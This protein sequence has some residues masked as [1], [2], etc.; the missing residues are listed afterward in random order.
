MIRI[1]AAMFDMYG[2]LAGFDPPRDQIQH[3]AALKFGIDI[4]RDRIDTGYHLA[5]EFMAKQNSTKPLRTMN[6]NEQWAFFSRY[7]QLILQGSG[8]EVDLSLAGEIWAEIR[9]QEYRITLFS[10]VLDG[11]RRLRRSGLTVGVVSNMNS[12]G[13]SLCEEMGLIQE[14]DFVVTSGETGYEKPA[15]RIFEVAIEKAGMDASQIVF[16]GDQIESDIKGA[17]NVGLNP[18][19]IDRFNGHP[20]YVDHPRATDMDSTIAIID[21]MNA[22]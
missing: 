3:R 18:I 22:R 9:K 6:G 1:K 16:V 13:D 7:E 4:N 2:T 5:D 14:I 17:D 21:N 15:P 20:T 8:H 10:D 11:L 12:T 19:L